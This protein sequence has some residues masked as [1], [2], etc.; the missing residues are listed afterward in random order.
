MEENKNTGIDLDSMVANMVNDIVNEAEVKGVELTENQKHEE[1]AHAALDEYTKTQQKIL[2]ITLDIEKFKEEHKDV[3]DALKKKTDEIAKLEAFATECK[4]DMLEEIKECDSILPLENESYKV[5]Y[6]KPTTKRNF[7]TE[8]FYSTYG[9]ETAMFKSY[10]TI[11]N[12]SGYIKVSAKK[13]K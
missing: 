1:T 7:N 5:T 2:E 4:T 11:S 9:P 12:V 13:H 8:K 3:F 10:V 6:V